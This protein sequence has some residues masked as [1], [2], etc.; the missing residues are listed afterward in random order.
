M[1]V[2]I[3]KTRIVSHCYDN[4]VP[5][6]GVFE[7]LPIHGKTGCRCVA[8]MNPMAQVEIALRFQRFSQCD[9]VDSIDQRPVQKRW[10]HPH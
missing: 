8:Y 7:E 3:P 2:G 4:F 6:A 9:G 10:H 1:M 5:V